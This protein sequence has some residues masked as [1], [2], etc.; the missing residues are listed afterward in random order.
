MLDDKT[1]RTDL[2]F[3]E[4][5]KCRKTITDVDTCIKTIRKKDTRIECSINK[6]SISLKKRIQFNCNKIRNGSIFIH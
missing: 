5:A 2:A 6:L 4:Q 3:H 1:K